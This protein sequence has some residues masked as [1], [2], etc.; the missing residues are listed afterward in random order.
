VPANPERATPDAAEPLWPERARRGF[1]NTATVGLPPQPSLA[2]LEVHLTAWADGQ[3]DPRAVDVDVERSRSAFARLVGTVPQDVAIGV[4]VS[5]FVGLVAASLPPTARVLVA[6]GDFTSVLFPFL[7]QERRGVTVRSVP[8]EHLAEAVDA[9]TDLVAVSA[10]QSADGRVIDLDALAA[11]ARHHGAEVLLDV[12]QAAG[13]MAIDAARFTYVVAGGYKWL[14]CPR[15][16][17]FMAVGGERAEGLLAHHAGW[18]AGR[19]PWDSI[20]GMPLRLAPGA[21]RLDVSPAWPCWVGAAGALELLADRGP[22]AI[23][24]HNG[25]LADALRAGLGLPPTASAIVSV[26]APGAGE[27]I[28]AAGVRASVRAGSARV[29][30]H[31][32]NDENDVDLALH[33]LR[34]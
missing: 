23:G 5:S 33:A 9:R 31:L 10:A 17:A 16:T 34:G 1:L 22:A 2:A 18:Y 4:A 27:R 19:D 11:A 21:R 32:Y 8:L 14:L 28:A 15:G 3:L 26:A 29:S 13:W 24:A 30:F 7:E 25:A 12:T 6:D 20:Y